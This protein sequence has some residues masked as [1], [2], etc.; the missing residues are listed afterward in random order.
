MP[1]ARLPVPQ[2]FMGLS[3][4]IFALLT[5]ATVSDVDGRAITSSV[6]FPVLLTATV[7]AVRTDRHGHGRPLLGLGA[8]LLT[9]FAGASSLAGLGIAHPGSHHWIYL[10]LVFATLGTALGLSAGGQRS[11]AGAA[12]LGQLHELPGRPDLEIIS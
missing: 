12:D 6:A 9:G 1:L 2:L 5:L 7:R 11:V 8:G 10:P 3:V 4:G